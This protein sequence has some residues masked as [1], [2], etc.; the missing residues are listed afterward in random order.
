MTDEIKSFDYIM[1]IDN[2][3]QSCISIDDQVI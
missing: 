2:S 1:R 3:Y